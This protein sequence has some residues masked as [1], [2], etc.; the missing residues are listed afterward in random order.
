MI[1]RHPQS[2]QLDSI[3]FTSSTLKKKVVRITDDPERYII[4]KDRVVRP[5]DL[6]R[7]MFIPPH[8]TRSSNDDIHLGISLGACLSNM[9]LNIHREPKDK[10]IEL[11][12]SYHPPTILDLSEARREMNISILK[13]SDCIWVELSE[14]EPGPYLVSNT[15]RIE[16]PSE[17]RS[18]KDLIHYISLLKEIADVPVIV[19]LRGMD[20]MLDLDSILVTEADAIHI[21]C[22]YDID[23]KEGPSFNGLTSEPVSTLIEANKHLKTFRSNDK[24]VKL[25]ISGP[26]RN[27]F[28][29]A[30][31]IAL[32]ADMVGIDMPIQK[33]MIELNKNGKVDWATIG[34]SIEQTIG[35]I[36]K[37]IDQCVDLVCP[38]GMI[39]LDRSRLHVDNYHTAALTGL[40]L[41]GYGQ[42]IPFWRH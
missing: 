31:M 26:F 10:L 24:G 32:G 13:S 5:I 14:P 23:G 19:S 21:S 39:D 34:E 25:L 36:Q 42:E 27:G 20:V 6:G 2:F 15:A 33:K 8:I 17:I 30:K 16:K 7:S 4:G 37:E 40:P 12:G 22:G 11:I 1:G 41:A 29:I 35:S 3:R 28:D 9:N 18:K 38:N